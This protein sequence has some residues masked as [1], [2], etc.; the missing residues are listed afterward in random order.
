MPSLLVSV[1]LSLLTLA[2]KAA[3]LRKRSLWGLAVVGSLGFGLSWALAPHG[4]E[5]AV[6]GQVAPFFI[7]F[8]VLGIQVQYTALSALHAWL[9]GQVRSAW[10]RLAGVV[11][12]F[13]M[14]YLLI[15]YLS[16]TLA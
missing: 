16:G 15:D 12:L 3:W 6:L 13:G 4:A 5:R 9:T 2:S 7:L 14:A 1:R 8:A 11:L 10:L